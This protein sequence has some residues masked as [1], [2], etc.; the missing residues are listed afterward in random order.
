MRID[1]NGRIGGAPGLLPELD[2]ADLNRSVVPNPGSGIYE[3]GNISMYRDSHFLVARWSPSKATPAA[4]E[5]LIDVMR[6]LLP[7]HAI[8]LCYDVGGWCVERYF[9]PDLAVRRIRE[10]TTARFC[11]PVSTT[12][13][14]QLEIDLSRT[15]PPF[16][17]LA[18]SLWQQMMTRPVHD[19]EHPFWKLA[20]SH[21]VWISA[22]DDSEEMAMSYVG[23]EAPIRRH[24]Q[25]SW[26]HE[27]FTRHK[28]WGNTLS[29]HER[30]VAEEYANVASSGRPRLDDV[31]GSIEL[32]NGMSIWL[33]YKRLI[34]PVP[35]SDHIPA[36]YIF[37]ELQPNRPFPIFHT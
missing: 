15:G 13:V 20:H 9:S 14:Q 37:T 10:L 1:A 33:Q 24:Y 8:L 7:G 19:R 6:W 18:W 22:D 35:I 28:N 27:C 12:K 23:P 32:E 21:A 31:V 16:L 4:T 3:F 36:I 2:P 30:R 17:S 34:L 11:D 5:R 29:R 26:F 25:A